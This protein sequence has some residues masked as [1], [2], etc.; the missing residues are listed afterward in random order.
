MFGLAPIMTGLIGRFFFQTYLHRLQWLG[1]GI[2]VCWVWPL[3]A[4]GGS[5]QH[6][7]PD[8]HRLNVDERI[9][10]LYVDFLGE[11]SQCTIAAHVSSHGFDSYLST[12]F[13]AAMLPFIWQYAPTQYA[14]N[15]STHWLILC[16]DYGFVDCNV[17]LFQTGTKHQGDHFIF[18][19]GTHTHACYALWCFTE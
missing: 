16:S 19:N 2:A 18:N 14:F 1:M 10:L 17:L 7:Q 3:S 5:D 13:T 12:V 9:R 11:K 15:Q 6:V 8:W 4:L